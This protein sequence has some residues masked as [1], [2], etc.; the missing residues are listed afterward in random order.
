VNFL[1]EIVE[2]IAEK[3]SNF[4][5]ALYMEYVEEIKVFSINFLQKN[6]K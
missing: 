3:C 5:K 6:A 1:L 2:E 4:S